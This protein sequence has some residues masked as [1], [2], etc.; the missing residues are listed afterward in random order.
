MAAAPI[1]LV[2]CTSSSGSGLSLVAAPF[3]AA[4]WS[5]VIP[6]GTGERIDRGQP[7]DVLPAEIDARVGQVIRIVNEDSRGHLVGPF[8]VGA[9]ETLT[10]RFAS[11][12]SFTG[13]CSV[14][15]SGDLR[16]VVQP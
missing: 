1:A 7:V 10:Q 15:P 14:H 8:Y 16:L 12:G 2:A 9:R 6:A 4:D 3:A 13:R 5:Y 11:P